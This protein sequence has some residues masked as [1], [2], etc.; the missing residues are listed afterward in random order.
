MT[1]TKG[2]KEGREGGEGGREELA[3]ALEL[4][5]CVSHRSLMLV[6]QQLEPLVHSRSACKNCVRASILG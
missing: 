3:A 1:M 4:L 6:A 2:G 5:T